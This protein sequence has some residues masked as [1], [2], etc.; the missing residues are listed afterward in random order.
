[1]FTE[2]SPLFIPV[3]IFLGS[4]IAP[5]LGW[6]RAYQ[7]SKKSQIEAAIANEPIPP[8]EPLDWKKVGISAFI[9]VLAGLIEF[10]LYN[11]AVSVGYADLLTAFIAG[12]GADKIVKNAIGI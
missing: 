8:V 6:V 3:A 1:M 5:V 2:L 7:D 12:F 10:G 4:V 11:T 9:G